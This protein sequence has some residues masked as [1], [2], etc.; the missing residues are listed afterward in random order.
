MKIKSIKEKPD[1]LLVTPLGDRLYEVN[2]TNIWVETD[3]GCLDFEFKE[4]FVTNFRSGGKAV[5]WLIDQIGDQK[6]SL[7]YL[8]HDAMY[9]PCEACNGEHPVSRE[10]ADE[11][12]EASLE[13]AGMWSPTRKLVYGSVRKF[14]KSA[15]EEDDKLTE[16]NKKLFSFKWTDKK[17]KK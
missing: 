6:K 1:K 3:E 11:F 5:D 9:T 8:L 14:G 2:G 13:W 4:G 12:L 7:C 10:F 15:Y 17:Q 16:K